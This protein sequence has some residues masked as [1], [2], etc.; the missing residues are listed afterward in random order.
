MGNMGAE[1]NLGEANEMMVGSTGEKG[2]VI[3]GDKSDCARDQ[4]LRASGGAPSTGVRPLNG[5][6]AMTTKV[7]AL[8]TAGVNTH[9]NDLSIITTVG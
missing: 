4:E 3:V 9:S 5:S 6:S 2:G 8:Y 1:G 7:G